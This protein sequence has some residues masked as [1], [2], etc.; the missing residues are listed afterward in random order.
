MSGQ[1]LK[2]EPQQPHWF[3]LISKLIKER[4]IFMS[5]ET[6]TFL[7]NSFNTTCMYYSKQS[8]AQMAMMKNSI[9]IQKHIIHCVCSACE[10]S[11]YVALDFTTKCGRG[12]I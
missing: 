9:Q 4:G 5:A 6:N 1:E 11:G 7:E 2:G 12:V 8:R 10:T 3:I